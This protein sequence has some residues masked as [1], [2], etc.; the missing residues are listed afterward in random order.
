V[1]GARA[2]FDGAITVVGSF[3]GE[4]ANA[5]AVLVTLPI[6]TGVLTEMTVAHSFHNSPFMRRLQD[7]TIAPVDSEIQ[8]ATGMTLPITCGTRNMLLVKLFTF[9]W[10]YL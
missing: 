3:H 1:F 8:P 6:V 9:E 2:K 10:S 7:C 5:L 4:T